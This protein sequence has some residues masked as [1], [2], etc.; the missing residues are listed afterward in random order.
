MCD[1]LR[2]IVAEQNARGVDTHF[3][4]CPGYHEW[5]SWRNAAKHFMELLFRE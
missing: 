3:Y 4:S 1:N 2:A 5:D